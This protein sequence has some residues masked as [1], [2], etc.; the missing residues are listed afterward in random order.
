M[1][2]EK[3]INTQKSVLGN[4]WAQNKIDPTVSCQ[5]QAEG[6]YP[7]AICNL[8]AARNISSNEVSDFLRPTLKHFLSDPFLLKD[9]REGINRILL[10]IHQKQKIT[11]YGDYDVDGATSTALFVRFFRMLN[12]EVDFYIPDRQQEGYG[13]NTAA[14]EKLA[15][16]GTHL[17]ITVDCG[18][19]AFEPIAA[20]KK[21]GVDVIVIDHHAGSEN[22]PASAALIN[23]N[24]IDEN[25]P[26]KHLAAVGVSFMV[27]VGITTVLKEE[28]YFKTTPEPDLISLLDIVALGT[29]CDVVSLTSLNR[30]F[31]S[32]GLKVLAQTKNKGLRYLM[33][34]L[35][36]D[37]NHLS[38]YHLGFVIGPRINAGGRLGTSSLGTTLLSSENENTI[39]L[40]AEELNRLNEERKLLQEATLLDADLQIDHNHPIITVSSDKWHQGV[41][42][43][44]AGKLKDKYHKPTFVIAIDPISQQGK[45]SARSIF[46]FDIGHSIHLAN[47]NNIILQG[48]GHQMAG[49]FSIEAS[50]IPEFNTFMCDH[51]REVLSTADAIPKRHFDEYLSLGSLTI[52]LYDTI[53]QLGPFGSGNP[54]PRFLFSNVTPKKIIVMQEKHLRCFL[55]DSI[56]GKTMEAILFQAFQ[57]PLGDFLLNHLYKQIDILGTLK[58][59]TWQ[60]RVT[61]KIFIEDARL[62]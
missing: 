35:N 32:Q 56:S 22:N 34:L 25:S 45:A 5:L 4:T 13:P 46:G 50:R 48:G 49:G 21:M 14:F 28:G 27:C 44:I 42:G 55:E 10:A 47:N 19:L 61:L 40:A 26:L 29:V 7:S 24:R 37:R 57:T 60:D 23:P 2:P 1:M 9:M 39:K 54:M 17:I 43:I 20:A 38:P 36:I 33:E 58:K 53:E 51:V 59:D 16:M 12:I 8:I 62:S 18:T 15:S 41:I 11:I 52:K 30:A 6:I 3:S 31:V